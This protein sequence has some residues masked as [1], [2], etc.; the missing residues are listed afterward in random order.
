[1]TEGE[2]LDYVKQ[3][4]LYGYMLYDDLDKDIVNFMSENAHLIDTMASEKTYIVYFES[5]GQKDEYWKEQVKKA[6]GEKADEYLKE[7]EEI[8]PYDR[9]RSHQILMN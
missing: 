6:F 3:F 7:W 9:N 2:G 5:S 4:N 8:K 1:M